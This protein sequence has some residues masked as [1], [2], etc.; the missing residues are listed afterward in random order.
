MKVLSL[1]WFKVLPARFG[2]QKGTA[3]F[4]EYLGKLAPLVCLCSN[5]NM[6]EGPLSYTLRPELLPGKKQLVHPGAWR[7]IAQ[8]VA[9]EKPTHLLLEYPYHAF[10]AVRACK[11]FGLK[12]VLHAHNLEYLRFKSL[13]HP[14]WRLL[15]AYE[16]W[17]CRKADLVLYKTDEDR[18]HAVR[19][20]NIDDSKTMVVPYGVEEKQP[21]SNG[22]ELRRQYRIPV[23]TPVFLFA[24]TLDYA[25][26]SDAVRMIYKEI[27]GRLDAMRKD[28]RII[29]CGRNSHPSFAHLDQLAHPNIIRTGEVPDLSPY[30]SAA[31]FFINPVL[32]GGGIQ[33]KIIDA[34][35][36]H[37]P[38][39]SFDFGLQGI[40]VQNAGEK[41]TSI[42]DGDWNSFASDMMS[43]EKNDS[44]TPP[45][46]LQAYDWS[47]IAQDVLSRMKAL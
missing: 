45:V 23:E 35:A 1:V 10:A 4:N 33:T 20:F 2:G 31:D 39:L 37:K 19:H 40:P 25:P 38:V 22:L 3:L 36:H 11:R 27:A 6:P 21:L 7:K 15:K 9:E 47:L 5:D 17:A 24:G 14:G 34:L 32:S 28:Y 43:M 12:L 16:S 46:F 26:N 44:R 41:I 29:I 18:M 42:K 30:Y 13:G 8:V